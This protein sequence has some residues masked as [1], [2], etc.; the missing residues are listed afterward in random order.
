MASS[1][2]S[3]SSAESVASS[4]RLGQDERLKKLQQRWAEKDELRQLSHAWKQQWRE[5]RRHPATSEGRQSPTSIERGEAGVG[6]RR[7]ESRGVS[8]NASGELEHHP[9]YVQAEHSSSEEQQ[10]SSYLPTS[11]HVSYYLHTK[12]PRYARKA[13]K[14]VRVVNEDERQSMLISQLGRGGGSAT[15]GRHEGEDD[16]Y[17]DRWGEHLLQP[18]VDYAM[19]EVLS[20]EEDGITTEQASPHTASNNERRQGE[21]DT[22]EVGVEK[23]LKALIGRQCPHHRWSL[24]ER[25]TPA[26]VVAVS[27]MPKGWGADEHKG[28]GSR[29]KADSFS[30]STPK[31]SLQYTLDPFSL[32]PPPSPSLHVSVFDSST[33]YV[34]GVCVHQPH[35]RYHEGGI[36]CC[37]KVED[38]LRALDEGLLFPRKASKEGGIM[39]RLTSSNRADY[40]IATLLVW[41]ATYAEEPIRYGGGLKQS[42]SFAMPLSFRPLPPT[43]FTVLPAE[44]RAGVRHDERTREVQHANRLAHV[45]ATNMRLEEDIEEMEARLEQWR[46]IQRP[47]K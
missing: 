11:L 40:R 5:G 46:A 9:H 41:N 47:L 34:E 37:P 27:A 36:Y 32:L 35:L 39:H 30:L 29:W 23:G 12:P 20:R 31:P 38:A 10:Q 26:E 42:F 43:S 44:E 24:G 25:S 4:L 2:S 33:L 22:F 28:T 1:I 16:E 18:F 6:E 7:W 15:E 13:Y 45:R 3:E 19:R 21:G 8:T 14:I 17:S